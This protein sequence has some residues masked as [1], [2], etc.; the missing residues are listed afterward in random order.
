M[1]E[2]R[3]ERGDEKEREGRKKDRGE[4]KI[5]WEKAKLRKKGEKKR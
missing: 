4:L 1:K 3:G 2:K 5:E